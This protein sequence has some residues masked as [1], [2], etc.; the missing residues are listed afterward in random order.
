MERSFGLWISLD[1]GAHWAQ[2]KGHD[3]PNVA[4]RD[5]WIQP[6]ESDLVIATHGRGIWII[7][8]ISPLRQL[9][10][11]IL[12][13]DAVFLESKPAQQRIY[14]Q[15]GWTDGD[16]TFVGENPP[17]AA[18]I[19]YYQKKRHIFGRMKL[20]VF[21]DKGALLDTLAPNSRRGLSRVEWPMRL[22]APRVP[23]A[24]VIAGE[25]TIGPRVLPGTYTVKLTRGTETY[26]TKLEVTLDR[27]AAYTL[28]DRKV[29]YAAAM[30]VYGLLRDLSFDVD[31]INS[32]HEALLA[33]AGNLP[34]GDALGAQLTALAAKAEDERKKIVA[35]KEGG[36]ITGEERIREKTSQLYG[37][38]VLYDGRPADYYVARIA[39][40][41]HDR[42]D[43]S[44]EFDSLLSQN[45]AA[46]NSALDARKLTPVQSLTREAWEK[47]DAVSSGSATA[48]G[49]IRWSE[50]GWR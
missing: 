23:P 43:V 21:D 4:V 38:I 32:V 26:T 24:A 44:D 36:A 33:R 12:S 42:K 10:P 41:T 29:E 46:V 7:D 6:R 17:D 14:S 3:F 20:E 13:K 28:S 31:R 48:A 1:A 49:A 50:V 45:L 40:L 9:T 25:A 11:E 35:T 5:L 8:D 18:L 37:A 39:S 27:R 30:R 15:G 16:A 2:Y 47:T 22:K 34:A 19:T